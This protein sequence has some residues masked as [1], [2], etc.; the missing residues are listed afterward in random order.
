MTITLTAKD[1]EGIRATA[2]VCR[3]R[4]MEFKARKNRAVDAQPPRQFVVWSASRNGF[5]PH[6][7]YDG[8]TPGSCWITLIEVTEDAVKGQIHSASV[9]IPRTR[10]D[11]YTWLSWLRRELEPVTA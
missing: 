1:L 4:I 11:F 3:K 6:A 8:S 9:Q 5:M 7:T 10:G 2:I